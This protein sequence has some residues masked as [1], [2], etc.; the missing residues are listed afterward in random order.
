VFRR[1]LTLIKQAEPRV[2][3]VVNGRDVP[4]DPEVLNLFDLWTARCP[5]DVL[6]K[7]RSMG[8]RYGDYYMHGYLQEPV[9]L[10][11]LRHDVAETLELLFAAGADAAGGGPWRAAEQPELKQALPEKTQS[12]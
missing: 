1:T 12:P 7:L 6:A 10:L 2:V 8:K 11:A 5:P 9:K 4:D 3:P